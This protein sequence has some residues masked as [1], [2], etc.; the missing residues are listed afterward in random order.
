MKDAIIVGAGPAGLHLAHRLASAGL[1]VAVVDDQTYIGEHAVCSGVIGEEAFR[2]FA[3]PERSVITKIHAFRAFSPG[4]KMLEHRSAPP[5]ARVVNK[6]E[7][8][9]DLALACRESGVKF[10]LGC[11]ATAVEREK[12]GIAIS[13]RSREGEEAVLKGRVAAI[14][15]GVKV[16]LTKDL[17]LVKPREFLRAVQAD[18][19]A[20]RDGTGHPTNI[21]VGKDVAP[22]GFAWKIPLGEGRYR[23]GVMSTSAAKPLFAS[24][25]EKAAPEVEAHAVQPAA[26]AIAQAPAGKI[27]ADRLL[28]VGEAAGHIKTSTGGGIYYGLLSAEFASEVLIEGFRR[29]QFSSQFLSAFERYAHSAF[30][31]EIFFG[32]LARKVLERFP[33]SF[34]EKIF[35]KAKE[36]D[37]F[38]KLN[39]NLSFDWHQRAILAGLRTLIDFS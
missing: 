37:F 15:S 2:R 29:G 34:I 16:A 6:S 12:H 7:F 14:A 3:L 23:V 36:M 32:H 17:G 13:C 11:F 1:S 39:G 35:A 38:S 9:K 26:K 21:Y 22:G 5:L 25:L 19:V 33:D 10:H 18:V 28:V 31:S 24:L 4:G 30:G 8:N 27:V 20:G